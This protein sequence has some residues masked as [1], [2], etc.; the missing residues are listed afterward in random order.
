MCLVASPLNESE[1]R[2]DLVLIETNWREN[3]FLQIKQ[4]LTKRTISWFPK[5][6]TLSNL[7]VWAKS[8]FSCLPLILNFVWFLR[9]STLNGDCKTGWL[10]IT[11]TWFSTS[12]SSSA[13]R[14]FDANVKC[15]TGRAYGPHFGSNSPLYG[16]WRE[17][18]ARGLPGGDG[19]FWNWLVHKCRQ[20]PLPDE[21]LVISRG[22]RSFNLYLID[23]I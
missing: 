23:F 17:S 6:I 13:D 16:A 21:F 22:Q 2:V 9:T 12:V 5:D 18:N 1:A 10:Q 11:V 14:R 8:I 3:I 19:R 4:Y 15:P 7:K 20:W